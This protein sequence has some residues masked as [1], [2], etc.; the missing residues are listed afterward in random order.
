MRRVRVIV[1]G[2]VQGVFF[3]VKCAEMAGELG[4]A[5]TVRNLGDGR[6]QAYFQGEGPAVEAALDWCRKGPSMAVVTTVEVTEQTPD[7]SDA[8]PPR[9]LIED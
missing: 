6:V 1:S 7:A 8:T 5:G 9:F 2:R 3:R 4:L